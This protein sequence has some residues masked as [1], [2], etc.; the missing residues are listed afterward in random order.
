M[1]RINF[2]TFLVTSSVILITFHIHVRPLWSE[3]NFSRLV[4]PNKDGKLVY[5]P[6]EKGN[7]IPDFSHYGYTGGGVALPDVPVV[8]TVIPQV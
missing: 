7:V 8:M 3:K 4:Y 2:I 6:D 1:K 5:T